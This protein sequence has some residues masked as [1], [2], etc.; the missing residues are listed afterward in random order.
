MIR[1]LIVDDEKSR[2]KV[3]AVLTMKCRMEAEAA[4]SA[5]ECLERLKLGADTGKPFDAVVLD[6]YMPGRHGDEIVQE[7]RRDYPFMAIIMLTAH[8]SAETATKTLRQGV[9]QYLEKT[10]FD[11]E[12][13]LAPVLR[14]G[15]A[16]HRLKQLRQELLGESRVASLY[17]RAAQVIRETIDLPSN[18]FLAIA[19][20]HN[21]GLEVSEWDQSGQETQH[22]KRLP[23]NHPLAQRILND[24]QVVR[25]KFGETGIEPV[26]PKAQALL[27][28]PIRDVGGAPAGFVDLECMTE[29]AFDEHA[30][31]VLLA[32]SELVALDRGIQCRIDVE[33]ALA[34]ADQVSQTSKEVAHYIRNAVH[35]LR[36]SFGLLRE[37]AAIWRTP[38]ASPTGLA[39]RIEQ[40]LQNED[41][42]DE[43]EGVLMQMAALGQQISILP[44]PL[45]LK[46][47]FAAREK[48][49]QAMAESAKARFVFN[50]PLED[51]WVQADEKQLLRAVDMLVE[52]AV[53][54]CA[55]EPPAEPVVELSL[56]CDNR[57]V[58]I[59]VRDNGPGFTAEDRAQL[60]KAQFSTKANIPL[61]GIGLFTAKRIVLE[62][63]GQIEARDVVPSGAE[64]IIQ[65]PLD[66]IHTKGLRQHSPGMP[67]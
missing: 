6:I 23:K 25:W 35:V 38:G 46:Q 32:L 66:H 52:N 33:S 65:L 14:A 29:Y 62:Q 42:L 55:I 51:V 12:R 57:S 49:Y 44:V 45:E 40:H 64:F 43:I 10:G 11:T 1:V 5:E 18:F 21:D 3:A 61:R 13:I 7:I 9:Y 67:S 58:Y 27:A 53:E 28:A 22:E 39:T 8:S 30:K 26:N 37:S 16:Q 15:V 48:N 41:N 36:S 17:S 24:R 63:D 54:A 2:L 34:R 47:V 50:V 60:F 4:A 31:D 20:R 19:S 59:S 56:T